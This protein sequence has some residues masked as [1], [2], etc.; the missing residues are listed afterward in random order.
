MISIEIEQATN[1]QA[2]KRA[3]KRANKQAN[4]QGNKQTKTKTNLGRLSNSNRS[5]GSGGSRD[6]VLLNICIR[7]LAFLAG[8]VASLPPVIVARVRIDDLDEIALAEREFPLDGR[9]VV[10]ERLDD[11]LARR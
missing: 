7:E 9:L 10:V 4:K 11:H 8:R 1:K 6:G 5:R 3:N 2:N